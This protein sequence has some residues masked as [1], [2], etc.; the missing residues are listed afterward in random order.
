LADALAAQEEALSYGGRDGI[1][2][3][4]LTE[5]VIARPCSGNHRSMASNSVLLHAIVSNHGF[6]DGNK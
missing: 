5:S 1:L 6:I 4:H 3:S 2:S